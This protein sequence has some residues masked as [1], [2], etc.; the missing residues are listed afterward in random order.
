MRSTLRTPPGSARVI[1]MFAFLT[2]MALAIPAPSQ[3]L[4]DGDAGPLL[5]LSL[6][7]RVELAGA[8]GVARAVEREE[9][10]DP[11]GTAV[12]VCD[13]WDLHHCLNATRRGAE[14]APRMDEV[15][16]EA[17]RRGA[18]I[19]HAPSGC[20][21]AYEGHPARDRAL[22]TPRSRSLPPDIDQWCDR[23]PAEEGGDYPIDQTDGGEDDDPV[24]HA[25]WAEK[26]ASMG[27][28]PRSPW[29]AQTDRLRIDP[30]RDYVSDDGEE[31]WSILE[32]R[33]IENVILLGVHTNMCVLGR[34]FGLRQM[35]KNGKNVVLMRDMTDTMYNPARPPFVS[36]YTGTDRIVEH[37]EKFVCPTITSDQLIGGRAFRF[38][39]DRRP[40]VVFLIAEDEYETEQT[41]PPFAE[42]SLGQDYRVSFVFGDDDDPHALEGLHVL[43]D[44]D[45]MFVSMRRR[46]LRAG[47]LE[48]IRDH[49][50]RGKPVSGI[51]TASHAFSL[52]GNPELSEGVAS[53]PE[54]DAR[55][56]GGSYTNH[57]PNG[58]E[59]AIAVADSAQAHPIL[60]DVDVPALIGKGS[61][62]KVRPLASSAT[63]LLIGTIP[64]QEPEPVA[65]TNLGPTGSRVFYT[66]LGHRGDFEQ[67][68]FRQLLRNAIDWTLEPLSY[69]R[70]DSQPQELADVPAAS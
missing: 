57:H 52:R 24:E 63:P 64:G 34:P 54:F 3:V 67:P 12:I 6:R 19:I 70:P 43:K 26:L 44:A 9:R 14:L 35:A 60:K 29:K 8:E 62:Y 1:P 69:P 49:V 56:L 42:E 41:L 18:T 58:I 40:H 27:R 4:T 25:A 13:M 17:R 31:I 10:W 2:G 20:M 45:L 16:E 23:I 28:D 33:S 46:P 50:A 36:H 66:S 65:W 30:E 48:M 15:L 38:Q 22:K 68:A 51:R 5:E 53:W 11:Q 7:S 59:S 21:A 32:D 47:H 39:D 37:I 55:V 61:L